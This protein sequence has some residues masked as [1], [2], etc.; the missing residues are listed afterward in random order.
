MAKDLSDLIE[1]VEAIETQFAV[2]FD[3]LYAVLEDDE[4][5][6][7]GELYALQGETLKQGVDVV[8]AAYDRRGLV[9]G[10]SSASVDARRFFGFEPFRL[11]LDHL[12][13]TKLE[14]IVLYVVGS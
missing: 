9:V 12:P 6:L 11:A 5:T 3:A 4:V 7:S 1:R 13:T 8:I 14:K 10:R 2:R